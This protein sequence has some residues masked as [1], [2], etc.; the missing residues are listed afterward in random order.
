MK[1]ELRFVLVLT[2]LYFIN[3]PLLAYIDPVTTTALIQGLIAIFATILIYI[4]TPSKIIKLVRI[5][6]LKI[7]K[8][9]KKNK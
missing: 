8:K 4:R 9:F 3:T 7:K 1:S 2:L 5:I 6:F